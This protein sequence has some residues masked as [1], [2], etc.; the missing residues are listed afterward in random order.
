MNEFSFPNGFHHCDDEM[1]HHAVAK[2][3]GENLPRFRL[4]HDKAFHGRG[5]VGTSM[6]FFLKLKKT[7]AKMSLK[8]GLAGV[9]GFFQPTG[10]ISAQKV[11]EARPSVRRS[12]GPEVR[13]LSSV[14]DLGTS[15][16]YIDII[17]VVIDLFV[18]GPGPVE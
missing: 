3:R 10:T 15:K 6:D 12:G 8:A 1:V 13:I 14:V 2:F 4:V 11:L 18:R 16:K 17:C 5:T 9:S 7:L